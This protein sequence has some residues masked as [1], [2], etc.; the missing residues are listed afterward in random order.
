MNSLVATI[1]SLLAIVQLSSGL[2]FSPLL[3]RA[4]PWGVIGRQ[5][6]QSP[7]SATVKAPPQVL[8]SSPSQV[9]FGHDDDLMRYKHELLNS[10]YN[11]SMTRSFDT[12]AQ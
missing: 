11:K 1:I 8:V 3:L 9:D 6:A 5:N 12:K 10:V 4:N 2:M 7:R